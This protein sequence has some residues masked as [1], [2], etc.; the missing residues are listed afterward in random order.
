[1]M[2]DGYG[3]GGMHVIWWF[4]W[5]SLL[6]WIFAMPYNIPGQRMKKNSPLDVLKNRLASGEITTE[7]Y[8]DRKKILE[9][10]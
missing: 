5:L 2:N 6:F 4:V 10:N 8:S 7:E 3:Y 9:S 1:M